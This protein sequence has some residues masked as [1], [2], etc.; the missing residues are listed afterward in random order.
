MGVRLRTGPRKTPLI[1]KLLLLCVP[2]QSRECLIGDLE[3]EFRTILLPEYGWIIA[4]LWY[5]EQAIC[6]LIPILWEQVK[7]VAGI[8]ALLRFFRVDPDKE[9]RIGGARQGVLLQKSARGMV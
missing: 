6:S 1:P 4:C 2:K 5:W 8:G 7:C 9:N 3:E